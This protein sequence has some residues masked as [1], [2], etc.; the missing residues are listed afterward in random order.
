MLLAIHKMG[1]DINVGEVTGEVLC[2]LLLVRHVGHTSST[3]RVNAEWQYNIGSLD[4]TASTADIRIV[5]LLH[6]Q[7]LPA[8]PFLLANKSRQAPLP[9]QDRLLVVGRSHEGK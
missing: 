3:D 6:C 8:M 2:T 5:S 7:S 1:G 4:C 9:A